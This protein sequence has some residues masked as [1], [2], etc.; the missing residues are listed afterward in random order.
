MICKPLI[1]ELYINKD[2][3]RKIKVYTLDQTASIFRYSLPVSLT[4]YA[5]DNL[6]AISRFQLVFYTNDEF[7][8]EFSSRNNMFEIEENNLNRFSEVVGDDL[9]ISNFSK[10]MSIGH[11]YNDNVEHNG[12]YE[13][14]FVLDAQHYNQRLRYY[15]I[16][17]NANDS[18]DI[19]NNNYT[20]LKIFLFDINNN[21]IDEI[22]FNYFN[23]NFFAQVYEEERVID[24]LKFLRD[25]YFNDIER[26]LDIIQ[27]SYVDWRVYFHIPDIVYDS[28]HED[29]SYLFTDIRGSIT[30]NGLTSRT[31]ILDANRSVNDRLSPQTPYEEGSEFGSV[32]PDFFDFF[33]NI[34]YN[35]H[36]GQNQFNIKLNLQVSLRPNSNSED[37]IQEIFEKDI[38]LNR[39]SDFI[40]ALT[41]AGAQS[42]IVSRGITNIDFNISTEISPTFIRINVNKDIDDRCLEFVKIKSVNLFNNAQSDFYLDKNLNKNS[43]INLVGKKLSSLFG[44]NNNFTLFSP[45]NISFL[46]IL[47][48]FELINLN[49]SIDS[50]TK[51]VVES[52][53][54]IFNKTDYKSNFNV[55]NETLTRY[56]QLDNLV[57]Q[58]ISLDSNASRYNTL[59]ISDIN[60]LQNSAFSFGY[61]AN[62]ENSQNIIN[63]IYEFLNNCVYKIYFKEKIADSVLIKQEYFYGKEIFDI[64][65]QDGRDIVY[66]KEEFL[67]SFLS[68]SIR[69][70]SKK[71]KSVKR[72]SL[73]N[74]ISNVSSDMSTRQTINIIRDYEDVIKGLKIIKKIEIK[75]IPI[76]KNIS[77]SKLRGTDNNNN[78]VFSSGDTTDQQFIKELSLSF[79]N[80]FYDSN[81]SL[82]YQRFLAYKKAY[83][84]NSETSSDSISLGQGLDLTRISLLQKEIASNLRPI[85]DYLFSGLYLNSNSSFS[86]TQTLRVEEFFN[87]SRLEEINYVDINNFIVQEPML[88][89]ENKYYDF[90]INNLNNIF[91][92]STNLAVNFSNFYNQN[93]KKPQNIKIFS[94]INHKDFYIDIEA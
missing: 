61:I 92:K 49:D 14:D 46:Q 39:N 28:R 9:F 22:D 42:S 45:N 76:L 51:K 8:A 18:R 70:L 71:I 72:A 65:L 74:F 69:D 48:R 19:K 43:E 13:V 58:A 33:K 75:A 85:W 29:G 52:P 23:S 12:I 57:N 63:G 7:A 87:T 84:Y 25:G 31:A 78:I 36:Q 94:E 11:Y 91:I 64:T 80:L 56:I 41:S 67:S 17:L 89:L 68:N 44:E 2:N 37:L 73:N 4:Q 38:T 10:N 83:F 21:I 30:Y 47:P 15:E 32:L 60:S 6:D 1:E 5:I 55:F 77:I 24:S 93:R 88:G 20:A 50:I 53:E 90:T 59:Y 34:F 54:I 3:Q 40:R 16:I 81:S 66:V 35:Y 27:N 82:S 62:T 79:I 26:N 86:N